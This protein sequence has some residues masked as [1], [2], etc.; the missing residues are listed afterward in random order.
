V[1]DGLMHVLL[2][3]GVLLAMYA[4]RAGSKVVRL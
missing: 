1:A 4:R 3:G 2:P